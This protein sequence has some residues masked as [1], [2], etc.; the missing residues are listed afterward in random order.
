MMK[1]E[2]ILYEKVNNELKCNLCSHRCVIKMGRRGICGVRENKGGKLYTLVHSKAIA[3]HIDPIEKK[4]FFHFH[5][6]AEV[7]SIS[8]AGC[9]FRCKHCQN[10][11]ISQI[12]KGNGNIIGKFL[13]PGEVVEIAKKENARGISYTYTE[14]TIFFEYAYDTAKLAHKENLHNNFVTNGYMTEDALN[15]INPYLDAANV[16]IKAFTDKFY[17]EICGARLEPVLDTIKRMKK[18]GIWIELTTLIIPTLNDS[19]DELKQIAEF[20]KNLDAGI[21]WHVSRFHPYY[22]LNDLPP[23]P[24]E[25]LIRAREIGLEAGLRYVYTGNIPGDAGENTYC[26]NCGE[27]LINRSGFSVVEN[28]VVNSRCFNCGVKIDGVGV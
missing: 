4:P 25:T 13:P 21:P 3:S 23:T 20:I 7:L 6:G 16:D 14:P 1:K 22:K 9:N 18:L 24:V 27:L 2:A 12:S 26:Y 17:R 19:A 28:K 15:M 11:E 5:P 8:T 10:S